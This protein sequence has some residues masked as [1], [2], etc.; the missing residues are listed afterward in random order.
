[1]AARLR[2]RMPWVLVL[3]AGS[4][5]GPVDGRVEAPVVAFGVPVPGFAMS[6]SIAYP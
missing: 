3:V 2:A 4:V 5:A 6:P 1:M